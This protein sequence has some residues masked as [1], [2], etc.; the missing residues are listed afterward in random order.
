MQRTETKRR[1]RRRLDWV[2]LRWQWYQLVRQTSHGDDHYHDDNHCYLRSL[3]TSPSSSSSSVAQST[4]CHRSTKTNNKAF[5]CT[6]EEATTSH[7]DWF[8]GG[9]TFDILSTF[10]YHRLFF[11]FVEK[12]TLQF[13]N[14]PGRLQLICSIPSSADHLLHTVITHKYKLKNTQIANVQLGQSCKLY[15]RRR[16]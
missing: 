3:L 1:R 2:K 6:L 7:T 9:F 11:Y 5:K 12:N 16:D 15:S 4:K 14:V 13:S 10:L 8:L